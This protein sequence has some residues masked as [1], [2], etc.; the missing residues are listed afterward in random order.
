MKQILTYHEKPACNQ[1]YLYCQCKYLKYENR[2]L[3][4]LTDTIIIG[5]KGRFFILIFNKKRHLIVLIS[6]DSIKYDSYYHQ[7]HQ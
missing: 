3:P 2:S 1:I 7:G 4:F 5:S 6:N